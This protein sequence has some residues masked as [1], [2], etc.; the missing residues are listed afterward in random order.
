LA[1]ILNRVLVVEDYEPFRRFVCSTLERSLD[2]QIVGEAADGFEAVRKAEELQPDL[3]VLDIGLPTL[4]GIEAARRI[5]KLC[6]ASRILF[7]SQESSADIVQEALSVG[8]FGYVLK[9]H[10]GSELVAAVQAVCR[11][12]RFISSRLAGH[13]LT[14]PSDTTARPLDHDTQSARRHEVSFYSDDQ[15]FLDDVAQ[16]IGTALQAGG[17]AIFVGTEAHRNGLLPRLQALGLDIGAAIEQGRYI[18]LDAADTLSTFMANGL[19]D[20]A[21]FMKLAGDLILNASSAAK[22]ECPLVAACGEGT[23][24]LWAKGN[25][26][27]AL[28]LERLW[29]EIRELYDVDILCGYPLASFQGGIGSHIFEKLCAAH[30]AIHSR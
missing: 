5:R 23:H 12:R 11:G 25:A 17:A 20:R 2:L 28:Q 13:D 7:V 26:E 18:P 24:L 1:T 14:R 15:W 19:P 10:A 8:A 21:R 27:A 16:F 9:A 3:I 4:N 30:T 22:P 6:P 29:D